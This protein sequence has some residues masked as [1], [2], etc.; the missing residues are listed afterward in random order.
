MTTRD[1]AVHNPFAELGDLLSLR[2]MYE[3]R[4]VVESVRPRQVPPAAKE[5]SAATDRATLTFREWYDDTM[6]VGAEVS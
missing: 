4:R 3:D 6:K 1:F 5:H 2:V